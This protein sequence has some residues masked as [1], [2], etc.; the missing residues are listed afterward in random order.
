M[1][2]Y[3]MTLSKLISYLQNPNM[4]RLIFVAVNITMYTDPVDG[5]LVTATVPCR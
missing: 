3:I 1:Q 5:L 2:L 4:S